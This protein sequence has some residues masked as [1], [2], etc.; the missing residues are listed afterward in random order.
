MQTFRSLRRSTTAL[1]FAGALALG[2]A[3]C[4]EDDGATDPAADDAG[5]EEEPADDAG[6]EEEPADDAG[7][8]EEEAS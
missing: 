6:M 3:A 1:A 2:A 4:A 7:M 5:M 8:E